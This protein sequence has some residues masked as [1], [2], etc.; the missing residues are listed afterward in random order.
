MYSDDEYEVR[1]YQSAR[2]VGKPMGYGAPHIPNK[3]ERK[4]LTRMMQKSGQTEEE[5]R[6]SKSN[7]Q[8]LAIAAKSMSKPKHG[9]SIQLKRLRRRI[10]LATN[11]P[12][13]DKR[14]DA[15]VKAYNRRPGWSM[16]SI[17]LTDAITEVLGKDFKVW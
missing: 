8:K 5:V 12:H 3:A 16:F 15:I 1:H 17:T 10:M 4:L 2:K 9:V 13:Y 7:R 11:L 14:I 6:E